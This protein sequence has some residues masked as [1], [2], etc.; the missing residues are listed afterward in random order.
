MV[1]FIPMVD[2]MFRRRSFLSF[3][4][5]Q[6]YRRFSAESKE[7]PS[8]SYCPI[9]CDKEFL[10]NVSLFFFL[11]LFLFLPSSCSSSPR[12]PLAAGLKSNYAACGY[13]IF[14]KTAQAFV[15]DPPMTKNC[16]F[17]IFEIK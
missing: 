7:L 13:C 16:I 2:G 11:R 17:S 12:T 1:I 4:H 14:H 8:S 5:L 15:Q 6:T 9:V 3:S 10:S